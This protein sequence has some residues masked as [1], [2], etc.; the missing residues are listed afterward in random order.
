MS[1]LQTHGLPFHTCGVA[2][3]LT[4]GCAHGRAFRR[5]VAYG[6]RGGGVLPGVEIG[7]GEASVAPSHRTPFDVEAGE[8]LGSPQPSTRPCSFQP[9]SR[10]SCTPVFMPIPPVGDMVCAESPARITRPSQKRSA[11]ISLR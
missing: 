4:D 11:S 3:L 6:L 10:A 8:Q 5:I 1:E 7:G 9:R 2:E